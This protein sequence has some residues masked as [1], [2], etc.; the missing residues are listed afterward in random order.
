MG[1]FCDGF[2]TVKIKPLGLRN[3]TR[4]ASIFVNCSRNGPPRESNRRSNR[5]RSNPKYRSEISPAATMFI[6]PRDPPQT[7]CP[8]LIHSKYVRRPSTLTRNNPVGSEYIRRWSCPWPMGLASSAGGAS[9]SK[10]Y[11]F[12]M[13]LRNNR[14]NSPSCAEV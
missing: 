7:Q 4:K 12:C 8:A 13:C 9:S 2:F 14:S 6:A 11:T 10:R 3:R 1:F 5:S